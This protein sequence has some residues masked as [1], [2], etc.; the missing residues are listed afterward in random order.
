VEAARD[1]FVIAPHDGCQLRQIIPKHYQIPIKA[2]HLCSHL[3]DSLIDSDNRQT[4]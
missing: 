4:T 2:S 1:S 3:F